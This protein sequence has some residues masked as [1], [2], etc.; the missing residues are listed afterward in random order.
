MGQHFFIT[1]KEDIL[2]R[3]FK[4]S[5]GWMG[6]PCGAVFF[7]GEYHVFFQNYPHAMRWGPMHWGHAV[8]RDL[9]SWEE[10]SPALIPDMSYEDGEGCLPGCALEHDGKIY[11]FY[12]S[13][14]ASSGNSVS[15]ASSSDGV[16][17]EKYEGN[18]VLMPPEASGGRLM[19]PFVFEEDGTF[20]M[21]AGSVKDGLG[22]IYEF[23]SK[24][25]FDWE[26]KGETETG[27]FLRGTIEHPAVF[28]VDGDRFLVFQSPADMPHRILFAR[29]GE[30]FT[31]ETGPDLYSPVVFSD[32]EGESVLV[33][34]LNDRIK[35]TSCLSIP[36]KIEGDLRGDLT[37]MPVDASCKYLIDESRFVEY[38]NGRLRIMFEG[39]ILFDKAYKECPDLL[40]LEDVGTV[41][42]F[43]D[44]GRETITC[45]IC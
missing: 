9:I 15:V 21:V 10:R 14:S 42:V 24:D 19:H 43:I 41:E 29:E 34:W 23:C 44:G 26:L 39:K 31:V 32:E 8:S 38:V 17:F 3:H 27:L 36:R 35:G 16:L 30:I 13:D 5:N 6:G 18:P 25:L 45:A 7:K 20:K 37:M 22:T 4:N 33:G 12:T 1:V 11:L 28:R 2:F 40:V